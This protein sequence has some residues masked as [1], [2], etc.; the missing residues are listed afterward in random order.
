M[1]I[2][3]LDT[4]TKREVALSEFSSSAKLPKM[5]CA[6]IEV[7]K[8]VLELRHERSSGFATGGGRGKRKFITSR[9][10]RVATVVECRER[11]L[12]AHYTL[13]D[14]DGEGAT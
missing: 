14:D 4:L 11:K 10:R 9:V 7:G 2:S 6:T 3:P 8:I 5:R 1:K 13:F 12:E